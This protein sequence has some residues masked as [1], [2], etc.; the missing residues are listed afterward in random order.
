MNAVL[1]QRR[2]LQPVLISGGRAL[3]SV[4][5]LYEELYSDGS[6]RLRRGRSLMTVPTFEALNGSKSSKAE[7]MKRVRPDLRPAIVAAATLLKS[8]EDECLL[9]DSHDGLV[10]GFFDSK[11]KVKP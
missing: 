2:Q 7:A 1:V 4:H 10:C 3:P 11:G 9:A 5:M 6:T 8:L